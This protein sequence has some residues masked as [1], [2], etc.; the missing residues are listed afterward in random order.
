[1]RIDAPAL[2]QVFNPTDFVGEWTMDEVGRMVGALVGLSLPSDSR[3]LA[4]T[5]RALDRAVFN[6]PVTL[7]PTLDL[8]AAD[9][10]QRNGGFAM[11]G[12]VN[13]SLDYHLW[14]LALSVGSR[15]KPRP[16]HTA[17]GYDVSSFYSLWQVGETVAAPA[18]SPAATATRYA[19]VKMLP[20]PAVHQMC[21]A[22]D[23]VVPDDTDLCK[24]ASRWRFWRIAFQRQRRMPTLSG[25]QSVM[26]RVRAQGYHLPAW[27][28]CVAS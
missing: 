28:L 24:V 11:F 6:S 10:T 14:A 21:E 25:V 23:I 18:G 8:V 9:A 26:V 12:D 4:L 15:Y 19:H 5:L 1:M 20:R 3:N 22:F 17:G 16:M 7:T 13:G 2:Y 27:R